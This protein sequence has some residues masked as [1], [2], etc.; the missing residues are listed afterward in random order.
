ML[1]TMEG[2]TPETPT[3]TGKRGTAIAL[4]VDFKAGLSF[5]HSAPASQ[6]I[7]AVISPVSMFPTLVKN[8]DWELL[9][10]QIG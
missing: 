2:V 9:E 1:P 8:G 7:L 10:G 3:A 6:T 4:S 5:P